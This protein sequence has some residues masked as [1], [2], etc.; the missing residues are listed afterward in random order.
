M[1]KAVQAHLYRNKDKPWCVL[2]YGVTRRGINKALQ[3]QRNSTTERHAVALA[4]QR[5][6]NQAAIAKQRRSKRLSRNRQANAAIADPIEIPVPN[7]S[8]PSTGVHAACKRKYKRGCRNS[9]QVRA[10]HLDAQDQAQIVSAAFKEACVLYCFLNTSE[11]QYDQ[12]SI[13]ILGKHEALLAKHSLHVPAVL[14]QLQT[15]PPTNATNIANS[16]VQQATNT[17]APNIDAPNVGAPNIDAP[18]IDAPH[19]DAPL[20]PQLF[21]SPPPRRMIRRRQQ[22]TPV[23]LA[24]TILLG[25]FKYVSAYMLCTIT[26]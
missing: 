6:G 18:N 22:P 23:A 21:T 17:D 13:R 14:D 1:H 20:S 2:T 26:M 7:P 24:I 19:T 4:A 8:V 12:T 11:A 9:R 25:C 3:R 10:H 15:E 16:G 5:R